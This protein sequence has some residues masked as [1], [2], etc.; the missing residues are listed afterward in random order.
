[1]NQGQTIPQMDEQLY[2]IINRKQKY[3]EAI[4]DAVPIAIV[5]VDENMR[6]DRINEAFRRMVNR[7]FREILGNHLGAGLCCEESLKLADPKSI[8]SCTN[9]ILA[10]TIKKVFADGH[11]LRNIEIQMVIRADGDKP[12][13]WFDVVAEP[14]NVDGKSH[15]LLA[16]H[17]ITEKKLVQQQFNQNMEI[18]SQF[19]STVSHELRTPMACIRESVE[20]VL[21]GS[22][23]RL[24]KQQKHFLEIAKKNI[25]RLQMLINDVLDFQKLE[26]GKMTIEPAEHEISQTAGHVFD[27]MELYAK[28]Q[29]VRLEL[30]LQKNLPKAQYDEHK[31]VQV[32]TNLLSNAIK[33][34]P[35]GGKV[36]FSVLSC[37][38]ELIIEVADTGIGIPKEDLAKIFERF[39]RVSRP[40]HQIQGTGLG[41]AIVQ[42]IV[43]MHGGRIQVQSEEN[44]G[45]VFTVYL[46]VHP[47]IVKDSLD[48]TCDEALEVQLNG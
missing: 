40:N 42:R 11:P 25:E 29:N 47:P 19:V 32:M 16:M 28:K 30:S 34:T 43:L 15:V 18:K 41:L 24:K 5:L 22:A 37:C 23:G 36:K 31:I 6:I 27:T 9:C 7:E 17:D 39:Y 12:C 35:A 33:F 48:E 4:F 1:M 10:N 44:K 13:L 2:Q 21:D 46:P 38:D 20:I 3:L 14:I 8:H 45:T 26:A